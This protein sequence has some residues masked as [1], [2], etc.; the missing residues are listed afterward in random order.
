MK[1]L[2]RLLEYKQTAL[3]KIKSFI[4]DHPEILEHYENSSYWYPYKHVSKTHIA[5]V[6]RDFYLS[7]ENEIMHFSS[8][9]K[10]SHLICDYMLDSIKLHFAIMCYDIQKMDT[11]QQMA[12]Q[13]IELN[14][15][16]FTSLFDIVGDNIDYQG[17][18]TLEYIQ[19]YIQDSLNQEQEI[20]NH[21]TYSQEEKRE[22]T[23][24]YQ[25]F[26]PYLHLLNP[27]IG[28]C[29]HYRLDKLLPHKP[30][31]NQAKI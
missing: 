18:N 22:Y 13:I 1:S 3:K 8:T 15:E 30:L 20:L 2:N 11:D 7:D 19:S 5:D 31:S 28:F 6:Y 17:K 10:D 29:S 12:K 27:S 9:P 24:G 16:I 23:Q 25:N 14:H 26:H 4:D 21:S